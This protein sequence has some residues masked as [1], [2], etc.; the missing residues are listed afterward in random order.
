VTLYDEDLDSTRTKSTYA[1]EV[2]SR[3]ENWYE[4]VAD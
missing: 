1:V 2:W 3:I 4:R